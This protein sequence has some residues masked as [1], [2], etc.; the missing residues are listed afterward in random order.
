MS[1]KHNQ[2]Y[3]NKKKML[4]AVIVSVSSIITPFALAAFITGLRMS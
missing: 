3:L 2:N 1:I 4:D